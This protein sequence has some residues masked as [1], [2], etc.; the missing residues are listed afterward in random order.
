MYYLIMGMR[1][2]TANIIFSYKICIIY[3]H[4]Y[5][6]LYFI[7]KAKWRYISSINIAPHSLALH[8]LYTSWVSAGS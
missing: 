7:S 8:I 1:C 6:L 2:I 3:Y 4:K 5:E